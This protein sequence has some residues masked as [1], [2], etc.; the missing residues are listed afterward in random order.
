MF[1]HLIFNGTLTDE[2]KYVRDVAYESDP[3]DP[4]DQWLKIPPQMDPNS[5]NITC[6]RSAYMSANKTQTA[7][8]IAGSEVGFGVASLPNHPGYDVV[9]HLGP[10]QVYMSKPP[11]GRLEDYVGD[12][13][14]FKI[15]YFRPANDTKWSAV[16]VTEI[17]FTIPKPTPPGKYLLRIK[18][19]MPTSSFNYSQWYVNCAHVNVIGNSGKTPK[20]F[21]RF[22][23]GMISWIPVSRSFFS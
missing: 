10:A 14:W 6:G 3:W 17:K 21:I 9:F 16:G 5:P 1:S 8:V 20:E 11:S 2:W 19:F 13:D 18:Q 12:G 15:A 4:S 7:D 23:P 22:P